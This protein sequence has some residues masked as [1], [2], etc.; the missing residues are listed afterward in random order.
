MVFINPN[1]SDVRKLLVS[2]ISR[3]SAME[4]NK[5][6]EQTMTYEEKLE[7][8]RNRKKAELLKD[9]K[10]D[11]WI[12]PELQNFTSKRRRFLDLDLKDQNLRSN[13]LLSSISNLNFS[14]L[15]TSSVSHLHNLERAQLATEQE[16]ENRATRNNDTRANTAARLKAIAHNNRD[17]WTVNYKKTANAENFESKLDELV[18]EAEATTEAKEGTNLSGFIV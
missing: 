2:L 10:N 16:R 15:V 8:E 12:L 7:T 13:L 5:P 1:P 17:A 11:E 18:K 3:M 14:S 6:E 4:S 9:W